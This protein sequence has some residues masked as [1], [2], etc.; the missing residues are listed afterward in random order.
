MRE[1]PFW[2]GSGEL[3]IT[4]GLYISTVLHCMEVVYNDEQS[5]RRHVEAGYRGDGKIL[6]ASR[7]PGKKNW[8]LK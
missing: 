7:S 1:G 3:R 5:S 2:Y 8:R 6:H 4:T